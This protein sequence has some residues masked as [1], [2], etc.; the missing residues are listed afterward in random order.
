M[1][2][3]KTLLHY[4]IVRKLG[5]GGMGTVYEAEDTRLGRSV[6]IKVLHDAEANDREARERFLREAR[7][8]AAIEHRNLSNVHAIEETADGSFYWS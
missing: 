3:G 5:S 1:A 8:V 7:A 2:S 4:R 6:A